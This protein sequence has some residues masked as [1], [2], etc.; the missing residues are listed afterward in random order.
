MTTSPARG[1]WLLLD[2]GNSALKWAL[3][4]PQGELGDQG[5]IAIGGAGFA[6]RIEA[7]FRVIAPPH[8]IFGCAVAAPACVRAIDELAALHLHRAVRWFSSPDRFC[9]DAVTLTNG[10]DE[11]SRLGPDRFHAMLAAHARWPGEPLLVVSVGTAVTCDFVRADGLF[12]GGTIS[13]GFALLRDALSQ[14]TARLPGDPGNP[15][16]QPT[17]T[18]DAIHTGLLD[19]VAGLVERRMRAARGCAGGRAP[20]I[21]LTGGGAL[22]L[23]PSLQELPSLGTIRHEPGLVL[24]GLALRARAEPPDS[25][26]SPGAAGAPA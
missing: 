3:G 6:G 2:A 22:D 1:G 23:M 10:Y 7:L 25:P 12:V 13:P 4:S 14:G 24:L 8:R 17:R 11:P 21:V 26:D 16:L 19:S 18:E 20:G 5:R 9:L 15:A